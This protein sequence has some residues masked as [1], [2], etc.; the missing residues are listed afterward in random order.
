V[1]IASIS[2]GEAWPYFA[3]FLLVVAGG[4]G[5]PM[6]GTAAVTAAAVLASQHVLSIEAVVAVACVA[7]VLGG[8][9]GYGGGRRWG[10]RLMERPGR[11]EE[12]RRHALDTGHELYRKWGWLAC[13]VIPSFMAGIARMVFAMFL[14][15]NTIAAISY[16]FATALPAYGAARVLSGYNDIPSIVGFIVGVAL[17]AF[18][19]LRLV[20]RRRASSARRPVG[21]SVGA[22]VPAAGAHAHA[23]TEHA[24]S[25]PAAPDPR[26]G[27]G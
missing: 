20:R 27:P 3:L 18:I 16:Q 1:S 25:A 5:V 10:V 26:D 15:F 8:V 9:L 22:D 7:A 12:R 2:P 17:L 24:S 6:I 14:I 4:A 23:V 11:L 13:F 21:G 19:G